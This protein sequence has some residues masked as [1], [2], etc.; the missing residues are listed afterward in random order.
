MINKKPLLPSIHPTHL[1]LENTIPQLKIFTIGLHILIL[2][3]LYQINR[4]SNKLTIFCSKTTLTPVFSTFLDKST[5]DNCV[6]QILTVS[7]RGNEEIVANISKRK[8]A[9][10][11]IFQQLGRVSVFLLGKNQN[12]DH[13]NLP[14]IM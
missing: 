8:N 2:H 4:L 6:Y 14:R 7:P 3:I 10:P 1:G 13:S 5:L 9:L 12:Q 11:D